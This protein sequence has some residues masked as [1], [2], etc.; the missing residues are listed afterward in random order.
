MKGE[1]ERERW[2]NYK[3]GVKRKERRKISNGNVVGDRNG[4]GNKGE[5]M[6]KEGERERE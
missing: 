5:N 6:E 1:R 2:I 3:S 4:R